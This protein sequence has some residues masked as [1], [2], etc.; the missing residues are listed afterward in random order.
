M[1]PIPSE[2]CKLQRKSAKS[3]VLS[4]LQ[5]WITEGTLQPGEK[6]VDIDLAR[7]LGVSRT[8][9]REALQILATQGFIEMKP[10]K[11]TRVTPIRYEDVYLL[12]PPLAALDSTA[13]ELAAEKMDRETLKNL[14]EINRHFA[15]A[16][17]AK[18]KQAAMKW[19]EQFHQTIVDA[20]D[21][22]YIRSFTSILQLHIRRLKVVFFEVSMIPAQESIEEHQAIIEAF[23]KRDKMSAARWMRQ[24]WLRAMEIVAAHMK[25]DMNKQE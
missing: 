8:P 12:Y 9:V 25:S 10:G 2:S 6:I 7:A 23:K 19:D 17:Q 21:N 5:E 13:A 22:T 3:L 16:V 11:E 4:Q 24:N 18:D 1:M 14:E 20:A 15:Q